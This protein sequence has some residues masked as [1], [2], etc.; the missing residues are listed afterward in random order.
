M[1]HRA[2]S[3]HCFRFDMRTNRQ[4]VIAADPVTPEVKWTKKTV[5]LF[6]LSRYVSYGIRNSFC[7][8]F[9]PPNN[10]MLLVLSLKISF[11]YEK[12]KGV[13]LTLMNFTCRSFKVRLHT[14][15][16][17]EKWKQSRYI[18]TIRKGLCD[19]AKYVIKAPFSYYWIYYSMKI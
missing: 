15:S 13:I 16:Q 9:Y 7:V 19:E 6:K 11:I 1:V 4:D 14:L 8:M 5:K 17:F 2:W 3:R 18:R 10:S 12:I